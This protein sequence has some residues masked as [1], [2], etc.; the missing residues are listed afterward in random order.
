MFEKLLAENQ[1]VILKFSCISARKNKSGAS[2]N[3]SPTPQKLEALLGGPGGAPILE[4]IHG[5]L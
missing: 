2:T 1:V 4:R 5:S 3:A